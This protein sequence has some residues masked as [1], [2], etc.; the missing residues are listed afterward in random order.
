[1]CHT[2]T[3]YGVASFMCMRELPDVINSSYY[4]VLDKECAR[5]L[6]DLKR[7]L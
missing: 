7:Y 3:N 6:E 5:N 2:V 4:I 1:M